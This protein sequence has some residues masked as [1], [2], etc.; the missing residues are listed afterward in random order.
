MEVAGMSSSNSIN[1]D[2]LG[3]P[4]SPKSSY[5]GQ[6]A[7]GESNQSL[8]LLP[9]LR[10]EHQPMRRQSARR[11]GDQVEIPPTPDDIQETE[12]RSN[13]SDFSDGLDQTMD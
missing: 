2:G 7:A 12:K 8:E 4:S 3:E 6:K 11:L 10:G 5:Q 13:R 1:Q 9:I